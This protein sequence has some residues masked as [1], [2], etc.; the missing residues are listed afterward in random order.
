MFAGL[1]STMRQFSIFTTPKRSFGGAPA[2]PVAR[3]PKTESR[4]NTPIC[5]TSFFGPSRGATSRSGEFVNKETAQ[6]LSAVWRAVR[7]R[8]ETI[9]SL[10]WD[11]YTDRN[12]AREKS[13]N[14]PVSRLLNKPHPLYNGQTLLETLQAWVTLTGN[15]FAVIQRFE[16]GKPFS[17]RHVANNL[18]QID[19]D[20]KLQKLWYTVRDSKSGKSMVVDGG[21]MIHLR[22]M[23]WDM[24]DGWGKSPI[25]VHRDAIGLGIAGQGYMSGLMKNGAHLSGLLSFDGVLDKEI[26]ESNRKS[27]QAA[28]AGIGN[29]GGTAVLQGG[30]KY[31]ALSLSP[32]DVKWLEVTEATTEDISR[33]FGVPM[34]KL[35]ALKRST[36][37]NIEHQGREFVTDTVRP[38]ANRIEAEFQKLFS[39]RSNS[40]F[41]FNLDSLMRGDTEA[42]AKMHGMM[43]NTGTLNRD[44]VRAL[45]GWN[46][47]PGGEGQ[48]H[49]YPINFAP[50][51]VLEAQ[52]QNTLTDGEEE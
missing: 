19:Y 16:S 26:A 13:P 10:S 50:M 22:S 20:E 12:G 47:I 33:I 14:H 7:V 2:L 11:I 4:D 38:D 32:A 5:H 43:L 18:V 52:Q 27:W 25:Q 51:S 48:V 49:L 24:E 41:L 30:M 1:R 37:N 3:T 46:P 42:R 6:T 35:S 36:N 9:G 17:V 44:E 40:Y 31:Q 45:E 34:H 21:D 29:A 8:S 23:V 39:D 28:Y 15:A